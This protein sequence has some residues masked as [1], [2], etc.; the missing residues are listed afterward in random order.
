MRAPLSLSAYYWAPMPRTGAVHS[1]WSRIVCEV[2]GWIMQPMGL[3]IQD[4][5]SGQTSRVFLWGKRREGKKKK[6]ILS[7]SQNSNVSEIQKQATN[8]HQ[9]LNPNFP[10]PQWSLTAQPTWVLWNL[11]QGTHAAKR[12]EEEMADFSV[13]FL[14]TNL[15]VNSGSNQ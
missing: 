4:V 7:L 9:Q 10:K 5:L 3:L 1:R 15:L 8:K 13:L 12:N 2:N 6:I 11:T 14:Y